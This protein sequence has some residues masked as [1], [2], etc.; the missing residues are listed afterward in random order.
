LS[1]QEIAA[2]IERNLDFL[3]TPARDVP[4]RQRSLRAAFE[5][6]WRLLDD[7]ERAILPALAVFA[8]GFTR[9][10]AEAVA[11][12]S[13]LTL[14][15]LMAKS[16]VERVDEGRYDLHEIVRQYA[17]EKLA[18]GDLAAARARHWRDFR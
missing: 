5:H 2:E 12:A 7:E 9:Q 17:A 1:C 6:S 16:L 4:P 8:G 11:G 10:A 13:L 15:S 14:A 18:A 3:S